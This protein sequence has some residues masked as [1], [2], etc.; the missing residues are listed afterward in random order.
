MFSMEITED[1][2]TTWFNESDDDLIRELLDNESPF[3]VLPQTFETEEAHL[4]KPRTNLV[5]EVYTES[6][7]AN[8]GLTDQS[9]GFHSRNAAVLE[10]KLMSKIDNKYTLKIRSCGNEMSDDG[11]KWRK[12]GQKSI[13]NSPHPR[14]YYRCT[15]PRC[16]AKK[17]VERSSQDSDTLVIT[18]EGLHLHFTYTNFLL[19][20]PQLIQPPTKR[21]KTNINQVQDRQFQE[22]EA[23]Q[24]QQI[25]ALFSQTTLAAARFNH[26]DKLCDVGPQGLL[27]DMVPLM[28]RRPYNSTTLSSSTSCTSS[29]PSSPPSSSS[30][31]L[32]WS[33]NIFTQYASVN[34]STI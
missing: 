18:Y 13:K 30:S 23:A 11:Y 27:E 6:T 16:S 21:S 10:E 17:Q 22:T 3:F 15:N 31:S 14:S 7:A 29:Y 2:G 5:S 9:N 8:T 26:Q 25:P 33:P 19:N 28:V 20:Q 32:S 24:T 12:Y 34:S 1:H 4:S